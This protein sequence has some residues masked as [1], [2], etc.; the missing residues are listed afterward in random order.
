MSLM[1]RKKQARAQVSAG[2]DRARQA[3]THV[4]PMT[5]SARESAAQGVHNA[6]DWA[7]PRMEKGVRGAREWAAPR[8][9]Q[10]AHGLQENV[11]PKVSEMLEK[12]AHKIEPP[13]AA[14]RRM[15]PKLVAGLTMI[16]A[17]AGAAAAVLVRRRSASPSDEM[18]DGEA[19]QDA[20][21]ERASTE[22]D[23]TVMAETGGSDGQKRR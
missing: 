19:G 4:G 3:A 10:A 5:Q 16:A 12:A 15:W 23:D 18:T 8:I 9:E 17:A 22:G 7:A 20:M 11:A 1:T 13:K 2:L 21:T 14:R 6:Q